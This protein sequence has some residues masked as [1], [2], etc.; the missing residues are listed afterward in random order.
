M[1]TDFLSVNF[2]AGIETLTLRGRI[3]LFVR[4][5][6][7]LSLT[8]CFSG[9]WSKAKANQPLQRFPVRKKPLKRL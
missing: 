7:W 1:D 2:S 6:I 3:S 9:V 8:P 5:A 4:E